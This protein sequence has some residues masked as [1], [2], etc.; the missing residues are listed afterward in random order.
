[1]SG[2][3]PLGSLRREPSRQAVS[4]AVRY[5]ALCPA[6]YGNSRP[7]P[8]PSGPWQLAQACTTLPSSPHI[9]SWRPRSL[10]AAPAWRVPELLTLFV[11]GLLATAAAVAAGA[12]APSDA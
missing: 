7:S 12:D 6:R 2:I 4:A 5:A 10:P 8:V 3:C 9:A 11:P 1:M